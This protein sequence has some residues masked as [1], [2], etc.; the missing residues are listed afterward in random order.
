MWTVG[1]SG[2]IV[3]G[4]I[5][6]AFVRSSHLYC[7]RFYDL[8]SFT[9]AF[10]HLNKHIEWF[11]EWILPAYFSLFWMEFD[12][13]LWSAPCILATTLLL[14]FNPYTIG[15]EN[16]MGT[17]QSA[18]RTRTYYVRSLITSYTLHV[19]WNHIYRIFSCLVSMDN[20]DGKCRC[21]HFVQWK[22]IGIPSHTHTLTFIHQFICCAAVIG[23][24]VG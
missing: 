23:S 22:R 24:V 8:F 19:Q 20:L 21:G 7:C 13:T 12:K 1:F 2:M 9:I 17:T 15:E 16:K 5:L 11:V 10:V 14:H 18:T 3:F 4:G 6:S